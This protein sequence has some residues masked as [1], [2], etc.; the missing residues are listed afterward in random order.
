VSVDGV[1][2]PIGTLHYKPFGEVRE[3]VGETPTDYTY[4]GQ[5]E[6]ADF[7]LHYYVARWYDSSIAHF[8]Q[9]DTI[10]PGAGNPAAWNR[11]GYVLNNPLTY[12]DP[13]G[14]WPVGDDVDIS[15]LSEIYAQEEQIH[16]EKEIGSQSQ[17]PPQNPD[18]YVLFSGELTTEQLTL[19]YKMLTLNIWYLIAGGV[20]ESGWIAAKTGIENTALELWASPYISE[21]GAKFLST[22]NLLQEAGKGVIIDAYI[23]LEIA[24]LE[25]VK[26]YVKDL[27]DISSENGGVAEVT[28]F[29]E[30]RLALMP[31]LSSP[32]IPARNVQANFPFTRFLMIYE[33]VL[34]TNFR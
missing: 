7:G 14:H 2:N 5:R 30:S 34:I 24:N 8:V 23:G 26:D 27:I 10:V 25:D 31:T 3:A 18:C 1:G 20:V 4:T 19:W 16:E 33:M 21:P 11:Y 12:V 9:A 28:L 29:A 22:V 15:K 6:E 17:C 32:D 13:S